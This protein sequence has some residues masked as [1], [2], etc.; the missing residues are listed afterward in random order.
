[1]VSRETIPD[2]LQGRIPALVQS[3][4]LESKAGLTISKQQSH[5][6]LCG[7]SGMIQDTITVLGERD[8]H[9]HTRKEPGNI[10]MEKYH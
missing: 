3:G 9:K 5:V 10:T 7:N 1:M 6:M 4:E 8:M 2:T